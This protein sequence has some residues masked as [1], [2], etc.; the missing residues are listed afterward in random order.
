M[1]PFCYFSGQSLVAK[2]IKFKGTYVG[3]DGFR[4]EILLATLKSSRFFG[5]HQ[6]VK[7]PTNLLLL[8][9]T[10]FTFQQEALFKSLSNELIWKRFFFGDGQV[11][12]D[13]MR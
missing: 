13:L 12:L 4:T 11:C 6:E 8:V 9:A 10:L 1:R 3:D 7:S 2:A 5:R